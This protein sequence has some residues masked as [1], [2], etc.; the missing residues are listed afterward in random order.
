VRLVTLD[1][2]ARLD[3]PGLSWVVENLIPAGVL[4]CLLGEP[5]AGKTY[6]ALQLGFAVAR[7][8]G[9]LGQRT[10][11]GTVL[12]LN[13]D[14]AEASWRQ[15]ITDLQAA[16][17]D[18][19]GPLVMLH[20]DD[21]I[22]PCDIMSISVQ[23]K[24]KTAIKQ[25]DPVLIIIDVLRELH[26]RKEASSDDMKVIGDTLLSI[27]KGRALVVIHH[28]SKISNKEFIR[29]VDLARGSSYITGKAETIWCFVNKDLH[30][31]PR[32][33]ERQVLEGTQLPSG[34]WAFNAPLICRGSPSSSS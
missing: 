1:E 21:D 26:N 6:L 18:T 13:L 10:R 33:A 12:Y 8:E 19:S 11:Q 7:G 32:F 27:T 25:A 29:P 2:Y 30:I 22:R 14:A 4:C 31:I 23:N 16:G 28:V 9:F 3:R 5:F 15:R 20:P 24:L 17:V 34:L